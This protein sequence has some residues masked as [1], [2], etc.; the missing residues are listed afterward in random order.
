VWEYATSPET[1]PLWQEG[2]LRVD[3]SNP[4][5]IPGIGTRN[6]CVHGE[7][8]IDEEVLDW[9]PPRYF[10]ERSTMGDLRTVS[11]FQLEPLEEG[12]RTHVTYR[13]RGETPEATAG[14]HAMWPMISASMEASAV[15]LNDLLTR[16]LGRDGS[17]QPEDATRA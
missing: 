17:P 6:H 4:R 1:R 3:Q 5:G 2:T 16:A 7:F 12:S 15:R 10:T 11:T 13:T 14:L 9:K 8:A